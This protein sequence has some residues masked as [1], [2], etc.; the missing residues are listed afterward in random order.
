M[1]DRIRRLFRKPP[2]QPAGELSER[3][4]ETD[5]LT[6]RERGLR[7]LDLVVIHEQRQWRSLIAQLL[8]IANDPTIEP[9]LGDW[10][11]ERERD[12]VKY[13]TNSPAW[14]HERHN[15]HRWAQATVQHIL[16]R[17]K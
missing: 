5:S 8:R 16:G 15:A 11:R 7:A 10:Q 14:W 12:V 2:A 6:P 4:R 3:V 1:L 17:V 9:S 13:P